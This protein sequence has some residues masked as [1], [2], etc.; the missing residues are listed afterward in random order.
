METLLFAGKVALVIGTGR[1]RPRRRAVPCDEGF[2]LVPAL[3]VGV[4]LPSR[5]RE[6]TPLALP[7][8]LFETP[9]SSATRC[10]ASGCASASSETHHLTSH[11][12]QSAQA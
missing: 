2:E 12:R 7:V 9:A 5:E 1:L 3:A 8:S 6:E 4:Q 11:L 10:A